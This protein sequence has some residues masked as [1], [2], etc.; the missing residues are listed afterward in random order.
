MIAVRDMKQLVTKAM[1]QPDDLVIVFEYEDSRGEVTRRVISPIRF[2]GND[3]FLAL[4]LCRE[5]PRQFHFSRCSNARIDAASNYLMPVPMVE[6]PHPNQP[7]A[8]LAS[9]AM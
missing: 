2:L 9:I 3:R 8:Q 1:R 4:C 7:A 6:R 5:E